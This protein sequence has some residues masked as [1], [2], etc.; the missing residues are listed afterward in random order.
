MAITYSISGGA[1]ATKFSI[2]ATTGKLTFKTA[3]DFE[4]PGD[5]NQDNIYEVQ[6]KAT[7]AGGASSTQDMR[8]TVK[9]VSEN[10]PPQIT[11]AAAVAVNENQ[12]AVTTVTATDPDE[13]PPGGGTPPPSGDYPNETN[14][15]VPSGVA[16]T[17]SGSVTLT[18][19]GKKIDAL[20]ISGTVK[21]NANNCQITRCFIDG[22][23]NAIAIETASGVTGTVISDCEIMSS[24]PPNYGIYGFLVQF[25]QILRCNV[26]HV[27]HVLNTNGGNTV[28]DCYFHTLVGPSD[29]HYECIY[30]GGGTHGPDT[31]RHNTMYAMDT[32]VIFLKSDYGPINNNVIDNNQLLQMP[33]SEIPSG[34]HTTSFTI[35]LT[36]T[37]SGNTVTNNKMQRGYYGYTSVDSQSNLTWSG[38]VDWETGAE[39]LPQA[40]KESEALK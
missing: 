33:A 8:V 40:K 24:N 3:P 1:D 27:Y 36:G 6:I 16:L 18:T 11:S 9:D 32:A 22:G 12:T 38:N 10:L 20:R 35:Y 31:Y 30:N 2:N 7:D 5:A 37:G 21:V 26:H 15:G 25:T 19:V 29:G 17:N 39:I 34:L 14:T 4:S 23:N 28:Q 13:A